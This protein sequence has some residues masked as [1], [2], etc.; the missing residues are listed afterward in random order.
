MNHLE[1]VLLQILLVVLGGWPNL[2]DPREPD[3]K[4][5]CWTEF[6]PVPGEEKG[7]ALPHSE[8]CKQ[9]LF[10][11]QRKGYGLSAILWQTSTSENFISSTFSGLSPF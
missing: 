11:F 3:G 6:I 9:I 4:L 5:P 2:I 8:L 10:H 1:T 7:L